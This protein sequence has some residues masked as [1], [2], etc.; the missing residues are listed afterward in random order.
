MSRKERCDEAE[1]KMNNLKYY[2]RNGNQRQKWERQV[3]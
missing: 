3:P 1:R 2:T